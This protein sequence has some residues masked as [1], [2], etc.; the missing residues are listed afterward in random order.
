MLILA[1]D[2][3]DPIGGVAVLSGDVVLST[4]SHDSTEDYSA[5]LLPAVDSVLAQS[6]LKLPNVDAFAVA[7]GPGSFT[8][9]RV[10]LTTVKAW[11]EVYLKPIAAVSRLEALAG[12]AHD[13]SPIVAACADGHRGQVFGA[14][15][16]REGPA[17]SDLLRL[18]EEIALPPGEF[19]EF[20]VKLAHGAPI[21]WVATNPD[22]LVKEEVWKSRAANGEPLA[23]VPGMLAVAIGN[24]GRR[25]LAS[26]KVTDSLSLDA[27][28]LRREDT[29][30]QWKDAVRSAG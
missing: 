18:G 20:A 30:S 2:T 29:K 9:V 10:G 22:L 5:W 17:T 13:G 15:F 4:L 24:L 7:A 12:F 28:Y 14:A 21:S 8:G 23:A 1:I 16:R 3:C 19:V 27:H 6:A 25:H 26:G 11:S